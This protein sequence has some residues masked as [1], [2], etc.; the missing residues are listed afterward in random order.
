[1]STITPQK[2]AVHLLKQRRHHR[3]WERAC[4]ILDELGFDRRFV[5]ELY[6]LGVVDEGAGWRLHNALRT[7]SPSEI[8]ALNSYYR[9]SLRMPRG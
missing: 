3:S 4:D 8:E 9:T 5:D 2:I 1:M 7:A 6:L